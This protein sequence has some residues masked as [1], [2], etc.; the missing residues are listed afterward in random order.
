MMKSSYA[1]RLCAELFED[2]RM[3]ASVAVNTV[4]DVDDG[5]TTSIAALIGDPGVD[6]VVSLREAITAAN[7]SS[8]HLKSDWTPTLPRNALRRF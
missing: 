8:P 5:D 4:A 1:R 3:L 7:N 2:R 6:G